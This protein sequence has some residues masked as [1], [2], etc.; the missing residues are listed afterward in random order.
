MQMENLY[1]LQQGEEIQIEIFSN[2]YWSSKK[3]NTTAGQKYRIW[4]EPSQFWKDWLTKTSP[5]GFFNILSYIAGQRVKG[6]K[7]F[8]LCGAYDKQE[9]TGFAIGKVKEFDAQGGELSFFANDTK[10]AYGNNKG[11]IIINV[12]R[13]T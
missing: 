7:C 9:S 12:I 2:E 8:C 10:W 5:E 4:S 11:S 6:A 1:D 13:L 3:I